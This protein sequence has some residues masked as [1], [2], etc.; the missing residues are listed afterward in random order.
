[1]RPGDPIAQEFREIV[2][3]MDEVWIQSVENRRVDARKALAELR[4]LARQYEVK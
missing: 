2:K 4:Q 1:V 3:G